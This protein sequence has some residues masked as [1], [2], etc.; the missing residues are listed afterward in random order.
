MPM[1]NGDV[2]Q[3]HAILCPI[4]DQRMVKGFNHIFTIGM[5]ENVCFEDAADGGSQTS[6]RVGGDHSGESAAILDVSFSVTIPLNL[7]DR[8]DFFQCDP[9]YRD[10]WIGHFL[11]QD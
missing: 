5:E 2:V 8:C 7:Q 4:Q 1:M 10:K 9:I 11:K 3:I 6:L